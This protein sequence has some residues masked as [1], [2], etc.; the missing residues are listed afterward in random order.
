MT[1]QIAFD[2]VDKIF[3]DVS[4]SDIVDDIKVGFQQ[5]AVDLIDARKTVVANEI[6][7][8]LAGEGE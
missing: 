8:Q 7:N 4:N 1:S 2:I 6:A 5:H 3:A